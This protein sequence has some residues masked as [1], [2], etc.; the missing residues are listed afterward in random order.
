VTE[1]SALLLR[2]DW[3]L[4]PGV[5]AFVTTR[6]GGH[7]L[8]PRQGFNLGLHTG[9]DPAAVAAN[10]SLL[11]QE[12]VLHTG[13][14]ELELQWVQQVHGTDVF[15]AADKAVHPAPEADAIYTD[16]PRL[17]LAVL[18]AD[19]LPVL[20][21]SHNGA[22]IAVAHAGWRGLLAG[23]LEVAVRSFRAAPGD[24]TAWLG[25]AIGPCHFEVGSEVRNAFVAA[26]TDQEQVATL[27]AFHPG[28]EQGK[29]LAD[30]Y[31]LARLRLR[32]TGLTDVSGAATCTICNHDRFYSYRLQAVTGRFA[33]LIAKTA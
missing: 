24:I 16:A 29:W 8:P 2:P 4:P 26:A 18:T 27:A 23:V 14:T 22:E 10:R 6:N 9:D 13:L 1:P 33:T 20:F 25:P 15:R 5:Q 11:A 21:C 28:Q 17:A 7:S 31:A 19:C 32:R 30:L 3:D 12:L